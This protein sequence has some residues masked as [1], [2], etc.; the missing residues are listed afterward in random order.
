MGGSIMTEIAALLDF[1]SRVVPAYPSD[2]VPDDVAYPYVT[3]EPRF[4]AWG[5]GD[6]PVQLNLWERT[7]S[8]ALVNGHV[9]E[10][11]ALIGYGGAPVACDTGWLWVKRGSPFAVPVTDPDDD[12]IKRRL[13]NIVIEFITD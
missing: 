8:D 7:T 5:D 12:A 2:N 11:A 10:F 13:L 9:R 1:F 6:V 3:V 4:G